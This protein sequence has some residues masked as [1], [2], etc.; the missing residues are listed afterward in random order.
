[1]LKNQRNIYHPF[2]ILLHRIIF[3]EVEELNKDLFKFAK[4]LVNSDEITDAATDPKSNLTTQGASQPD[5]DPCK[6]Y[7]GKVDCITKFV[8]DIMIPASQGWTEDHFMELS[9]KSMPTEGKLNFSTWTTYYTPNTWQ[10][11][12][13]HRD[14][15]FTG[16]YYIKMPEQSGGEF[17]IQNPHLQSTQPFDG[18]WT[19][20]K[21][22]IPKEG[23]LIIIP[24]W[25]QHYPKPFSSGERCVIVFDA[26]YTLNT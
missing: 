20:Q 5:I 14:K 17:V 24:S 18:G 8:D 3:E 6:E 26:Q 11:P 22:M 13:I 19:V 25:L 9:G 16:V 4:D 7:Y 21:E 12:H 23:E 15:L 1:M 10:I 2:P